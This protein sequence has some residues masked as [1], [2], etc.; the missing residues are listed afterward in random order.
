MYLINGYEVN[1][2]LHVRLKLTCSL[3]TPFTSFWKQCVWNLWKQPKH[4]E[5]HQ[6]SRDFYFALSATYE[7]NPIIRHVILTASVENS[8]I[9]RCVKAV[10]VIQCSGKCNRNGVD[11]DNGDF[12]RHIRCTSH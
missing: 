2:Y 4:N 3:R 12:S 5:W 6:L 10:D 8:S 7:S 9:C 1:C 11:H